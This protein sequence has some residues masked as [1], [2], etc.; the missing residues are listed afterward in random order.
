MIKEKTVAEQLRALADRLDDEGEGALDFGDEM[1]R[2]SVRDEVSRVLDE[3]LPAD[4]SPFLAEVTAMADKVAT[5]VC[6]FLNDL[7]ENK[8]SPTT[9]INWDDPRITSGRGDGKP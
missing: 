8:T 9:P 3:Q 2:V 6:V 7:M 5:A 1:L 4:V